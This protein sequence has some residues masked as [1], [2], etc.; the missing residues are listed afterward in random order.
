MNC[1]VCTHP[2]NRVIGNDAA[3][4][5]RECARCG[6]RWS[7][8]EVEARELDRLKDIER[9]AAAMRDLLPQD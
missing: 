6:N 1:P 2:E 3:R 8:V 7:T 4:R 5:R 9:A